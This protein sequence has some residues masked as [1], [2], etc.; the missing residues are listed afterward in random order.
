MKLSA[1]GLVLF[2]APTTIG[3]GM[4]MPH[5]GSGGGS[6]GSAYHP[7]QDI[8]DT[9]R[10]GEAKSDQ[11]TDPILDQEIAK[12]EKDVLH[13]IAMTQGKEPM[14]AGM[15]PYEPASQAL[16]ELRAAKFKMRIEPVTNAAGGSV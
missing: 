6:G 4:L 9:V 11:T 12:Q 10:A 16:T 14:A 7:G 15:P 5:G 2:L 13:A 3:C 8:K 1:V